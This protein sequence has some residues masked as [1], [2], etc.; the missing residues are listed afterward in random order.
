MNDNPEVEGNA[1]NYADGGAHDAQGQSP[2]RG[3]QGR[4]IGQGECIVAQ[5][6]CVDYITFEQGFFWQKQ[7]NHCENSELGPPVRKSPNALLPGNQALKEYVQR[8][9]CREGT[10]TSGKLKMCMP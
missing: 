2:L 8:A 1:A 6:E 5:G 3:G 10:K 9:P 4:P 7:W